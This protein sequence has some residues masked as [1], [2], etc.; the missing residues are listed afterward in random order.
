MMGHCEHVVVI[1]SGVVVGKE[2]VGVRVVLMDNL[3][4]FNQTGV[5][6]KL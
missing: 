3:M 6:E 5:K 4:S 2:V 1:L